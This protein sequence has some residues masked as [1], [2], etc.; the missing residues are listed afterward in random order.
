MSDKTQERLLS[1]LIGFVSIFM[2][3]YLAWQLWL[4]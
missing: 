1:L 3:G 2:A 4:R